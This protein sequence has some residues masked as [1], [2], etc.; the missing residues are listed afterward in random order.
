MGSIPCGSIWCIRLQTIPIVEHTIDAAKG[1]Q[2]QKSDLR[3]QAYLSIDRITSLEL[4]LVWFPVMDEP[5]V[6]R[7][8]KF[9]ASS[10]NGKK[11]ARLGVTGEGVLTGKEI[12]DQERAVLQI[13]ARGLGFTE[14]PHWLKGR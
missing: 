11:L 7:Q 3:V 14:W 1:T 12:S 9:N 10:K 13:F 8:D 5:L 4:N 2:I 6:L